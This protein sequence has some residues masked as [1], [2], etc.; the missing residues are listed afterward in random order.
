MD[1]NKSLINLDFA[2][3]LGV[4]ASYCGSLIF[5]FARDPETLFSNLPLVALCAWMMLDAWWRWR[6]D[7]EGE[8]ERVRH[9]LLMSGYVSRQLALAGV[10]AWLLVPQMRVIPPGARAPVLLALLIVPDLALRRYFGVR[11]ED[12]VRDRPEWMRSAQRVIFTS[13]AGFVFIC[14]LGVALAVWMN[15]SAFARIPMIK[16]VPAA[17]R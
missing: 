5:P 4:L 16:P 9:V 15:R 3:N 1:T 13:A 17:A 7:S 12:E 11:A 10:C 14:V 8:D 2:L 6:K